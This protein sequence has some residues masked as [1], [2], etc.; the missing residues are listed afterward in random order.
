MQGTLGP[1][2]YVVA[3]H[4]ERLPPQL[5]AGLGRSVI[6]VVPSGLAPPPA[7]QPAFTVTG[8]VGYMLG[9]RARAQARATAERSAGNGSGARL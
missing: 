6:L 8:C 7:G 3:Q 5:Q 9:V 1:L 4:L 2:F